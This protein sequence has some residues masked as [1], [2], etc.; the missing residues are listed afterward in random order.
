MSLRKKN[1]KRRKESETVATC[2][3]AE[4]EKEKKDWFA[5]MKKKTDSGISYYFHSV[6]YNWKIGKHKIKFLCI[7]GS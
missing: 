2:V 5:N 1:C 3:T 6:L 4:D 7:Y